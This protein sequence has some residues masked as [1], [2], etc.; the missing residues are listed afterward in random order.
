MQCGNRGIT[1]NDKIW[2]VAKPLQAAVPNISMDVIIWARREA[3]KFNLPHGSEDKTHDNNAPRK[4]FRREELT[5]RQEVDDSR[6]R[7]RGHERRSTSIAEGACA[8]R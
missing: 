5:D 8:D 3:K 1:R 7:Q 4:S 2:V 6:S